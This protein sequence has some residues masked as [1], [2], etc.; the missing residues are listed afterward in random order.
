MRFSLF[1]DVYY[2]SFAATKLVFTNF[3]PGSRLTYDGP[4]MYLLPALYET[5]R[6]DD[7]NAHVAFLIGKN[8]SFERR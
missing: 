2:R 8:R 1:S 6:M 5:H 4:I 3:G 7:V